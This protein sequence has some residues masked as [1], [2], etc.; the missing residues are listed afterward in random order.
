MVGV[1]LILAMLASFLGECNSRPL[2]PWK[3]DLGID[4]VGPNIL[5]YLA[6]IFGTKQALTHL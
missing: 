3:P 2:A 1:Q 5:T 6:D 4:H